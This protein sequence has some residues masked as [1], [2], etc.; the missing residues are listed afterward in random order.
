MQ[1]QKLARKL[2]KLL[3]DTAK[4]FKMSTKRWTELRR[5]AHDMGF[6]VKHGPMRQR[7]RGQRQRRL[8]RYKTLQQTRFVQWKRWASH[9]WLNNL[10]A[11]QQ[12][13]RTAS[14]PKRQQKKAK[15]LL[16]R[17]ENVTLIG[18]M[19]VYK[20]W[21]ARLTTLSLSTQAKWSVLPT[22]AYSVEKTI[23]Q[24][25]KLHEVA[26]DFILKCQLE[27]NTYNGVCVSGTQTW[28]V[29]HIGQLP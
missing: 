9:A 8:L 17:S 19:V 10:S 12:Y 24:L 5:T 4:F 27:L 25:S 21:A 13:L 16:K 26:E 15:W 14:F 23:C 7:S 2:D 29:W 18:G 20:R 28:K 3:R 11:L 22:L 1:V 6:H